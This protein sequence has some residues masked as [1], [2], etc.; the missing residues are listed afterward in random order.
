VPTFSKSKCRVGG[1][2]RKSV[3]T[4]RPKSR[5]APRGKGTLLIGNRSGFQSVKRSLHDVIKK[6]REEADEGYDERKAG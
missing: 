4:A 5:K 3:R 1:G 6:K 2:K